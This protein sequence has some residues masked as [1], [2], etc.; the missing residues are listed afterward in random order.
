MEA[1]ESVPIRPRSVLPQAQILS[2]CR[3]T[4]CA[5]WEAEG[6]PMTVTRA[7]S[8]AVL[9]AAAMI[10]AANAQNSAACHARNGAWHGR[11]PWHGRPRF[12][13]PADWPAARL[14]A[15]VGDARGDPGEHQ[16]QSGR[17]GAHTRYPRTALSLRRARPG[18]GSDWHRPRNM[19]MSAVLR[20]ASS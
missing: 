10:P 18:L 2:I 8:L 12:W 13:R 4:I 7:L 3:G 15:G 19:W 17:A 16:N 5:R 14:L 1:A 20:P 11:R 6:M 9:A